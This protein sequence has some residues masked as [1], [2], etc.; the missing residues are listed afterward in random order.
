MNKYTL[1]YLLCLFAPSISFTYAPMS[2]RT[3]EFDVEDI[4]RYD[5]SNNIF[6]YVEPCEKDHKCESAMLSNPNVGICVNHKQAEI[7]F[8]SG[9]ETD[10]NCDSNSNLKCVNKICTLE[11]G[12]SPILMPDI[13]NSYYYCPNGLI[14]V[15]DNSGNYK[16]EKEEN[17]A[18]KGLCYLND[19]GAIK[20][21]LPQYAKMELNGEITLD[22]E[23]NSYVKLKT[24]ANLIGS[25]DEGK[26]VKD[27]K[28]CKSGFALQ[29]YPNGEI[30]NSATT[31]MADKY[32]KCVQY[33]GIEYK[34]NSG[35]CIIKYIL[36]KNNYNYDVDKV[37]I[38]LYD[39][40]VSK[41][42]FCNSFKFRK[43]ELDLFKQYID[44]VNELGDECKKNKY[45]DEP[46]TCRNDELRKLNYF[47]NNVEEYLLYKNEDE[48]TEYLLQQVYPS[49]G[50]QFTK[51][52]GSKYL[53]NNFM[54][55]LIL[56]LL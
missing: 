51:T 38:F 49:Y 16:C 3:F 37:D 48:I 27:E 52:D 23:A 4:C 31:P 19:N 14:P 24:A 1:I 22:T 50:V 46:F 15:K 30:K 13:F 26:W 2:K 5:D 18:M 35:S 36:N 43:A 10:D 55:L 7:S 20:E 39:N 17:N 8:G 54:C 32:L 29:F 41:N 12:D 45:Y 42:A 11:E 33:D 34:K 6:R 40:Y 25:V 28:A 53:I 9:C 56:L 44:K 21:A 47:Y